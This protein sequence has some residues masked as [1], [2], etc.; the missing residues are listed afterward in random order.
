MILDVTAIAPV[1]NPFDKSA[2]SARPFAI[3]LPLYLK[4]Y[5][6]FAAPCGG[7]ASFRN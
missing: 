2:H 5:A 7:E 1:V 3:D 6:A 4:V